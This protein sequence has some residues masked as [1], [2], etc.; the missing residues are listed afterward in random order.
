VS[1]LIG[2]LIGLVSGWL[3]FALTDAW[4][5]KRAGLAAARAVYMEM[6]GSLTSMRRMEAVGFWTGAPEGPRR[7]A[8]EAHAGSLLLVLTPDAVNAL[9]FAYAEFD[10]I[11]WIV[12]ATEPLVLS[13]E[14][15]DDDAFEERVALLREE[16]AEPL[17]RAIAIVEEAMITLSGAAMPW[18][19]RLVVFRSVR[20]AIRGGLLSPATVAEEEA[21]SERDLI[22]QV[23]SVQRLAA[24]DSSSDHD[25]GENEA[26]L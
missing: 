21:A 3:L 20:R 26:R 16:N 15:L 10:K 11:A 6:Q 14:V 25:T 23:E 8:Y 22:K 12:R 13:D 18:W 1:T 4:R 9:M 17:S 7:V 19:Q 24:P 2:I 5:E